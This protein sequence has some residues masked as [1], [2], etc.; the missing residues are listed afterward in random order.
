MVTSGCNSKFISVNAYVKYEPVKTG[1][2]TSTNF[3]I[4][5][6]KPHMGYGIWRDNIRNKDFV[7]ITLLDDYKCHKK[8][9]YY[10]YES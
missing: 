5:I 7:L 9:N 8:L 2:R 1:T 6:C 3:G 10:D 4:Y